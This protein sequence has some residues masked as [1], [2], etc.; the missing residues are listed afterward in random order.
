MI[1]ALLPSRQSVDW[2]VTSQRRRLIL[3]AAG[4]LGL[5][6]LYAW[7]VLLSPIASPVTLFTWLG[8]AA[9]AWRPRVGL[10]FAFVMVLLFE[11]GNAD[12]MMAPG[13]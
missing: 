8:V 3:L 1:D 2:H 5:S 4:A 9:I 10:Y 11:A 13:A 6:V 7:L 12:Q